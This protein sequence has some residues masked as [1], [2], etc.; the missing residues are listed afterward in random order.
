MNYK[1]NAYS[2]GDFLKPDFYYHKP[3]LI[4]ADRRVRARNPEHIIIIV[5]F[6]PH[7]V[8]SIIPWLN[9]HKDKYDYVF[10]YY[11]PLLQENEKAVK[12]LGV[13]TW[14][15]DYK[16]P[17]K[18]FSVSTLVGKKCKKG[19]PG[20]AMRHHLWDAQEGISIPKKF[21]LSSHSMF[22]W[23]NP[24]THLILHDKKDPLFDSMFHIV[25]ENIQLKNMFSE[26]LVDCFQ[27]KTVPIY[28][29][30]PDIGDYFN[31]N[32]IFVA[33]NVS[34]IIAVCNGLTPEVYANMLPAIEDNYTL[35][36]RYVDFNKN[37]DDT[38]KKTLIDDV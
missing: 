6:E 17:I 3:V 2:K 34:D 25:I 9:G 29:G 30:A 13:C 26:K 19:L 28:C 18:E 15:R 22:R 8:A 10:T 35:S 37:L 5:L 33:N 4:Y 32:G 20:H 16:F 24:E 7:G 31:I 23:A 36:M 14:I 21:F 11:E 12:Y 1:A 27:T 38:I